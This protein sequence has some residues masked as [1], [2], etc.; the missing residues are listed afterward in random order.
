[1][2]SK[3]TDLC[4]HSVEGGDVA[5]TVRDYHT[6]HTVA[7]EERNAGYRALARQFYEL[8]TDFYEYGWGHSFHFAPRRKS[9]SLKDSIRRYEHFVAG[10]LGLKAGMSVLDI[11]CGV[12]GPMR[13][14]SRYSGARITGVNISGY[15]IA[16]GVR[17]NRA[18]RL[19]DRCGFLCADF[20]R[21]PLAA[22]S[23]AAAY[24]FEATCHAPAADRKTLYSEIFRVLKPGASFAG[25]DWCLTASFDSSHPLHLAIKK[26]IEVGNGLP[27]ILPVPVLMGA[28]SAA[29]FEIVEHRDLAP[30]CSRETP[31]YLPLAAGW[32]LTGIKYTRAGRWFTN[33]AVR[34]LEAA[35]V[36][37]RGAAAVSD[38]LN[39]AAEA[40]VLGGE[41][42]IFTPLY[43]FH[44]RKPC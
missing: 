40:L 2:N 8:V 7:L 42:G 34:T 30:E 23:Y 35:R 10:T 21:L 36:L 29:G 19:D 43:F 17:H 24:E 12:G 6:L 32:S 13:C 33:R 28:L 31:W 26:G 1:M 5:R 22:E 15:Q 39:A 41:T 20:L 4:T 38:M 9:E 18:Q 3:L 37:P 27:D 44:V 11:G 16:R 25:G 14:I